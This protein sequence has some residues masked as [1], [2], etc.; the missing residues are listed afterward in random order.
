MNRNSWIAVIVIVVLIIIGIF[1]YKSN[2]APSGADI[3]LEG[4]P[5]GVTTVRPYGQME[6]KIGETASFRGITITPLSVIEDSRCPQNVQCIQAG[7]VRVNVRSELDS[8]ATREDIVKLNSTSTID[9]FK[10]ALVKVT[11]NTTAGKTIANGDYRFTFEV[12][13]GAVTD[14]ELIGK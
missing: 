5:S 13:Q 4:A 7:T 9:T 14:N 12:R 2:K 11:P 1:I 10:V 3:G 8:G 6:I